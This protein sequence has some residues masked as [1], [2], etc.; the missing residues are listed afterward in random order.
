MDSEPC[1]H[2]VDI[3]KRNRLELINNIFGDALL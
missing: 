2:L 1:G 3:R